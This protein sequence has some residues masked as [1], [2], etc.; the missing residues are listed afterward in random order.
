MTAEI[1]PDSVP[2]PFLRAVMAWSDKTLMDR[3]SAGIAVRRNK[4][5]WDLR[6]TVNRHTRRLEE[7]AAVAKS[8]NVE[9][10]D[11]KRKKR[12]EIEKLE[13][14]VQEKKGELVPMADVQGQ[15]GEL[16]AMHQAELDSIGARLAGRLLACDSEAQIAESIQGA[17]REARKRL[18][19]RLA[20][21]ADSA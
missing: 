21:L 17:I 13:L 10:F 4:Q 3:E 1:A 11:D 9:D 7:K 14:Q 8:S 2:R 6:E 15:I 19:S 12:A 20:Q 16:L 18:A 5:R